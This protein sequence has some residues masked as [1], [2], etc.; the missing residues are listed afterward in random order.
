MYMRECMTAGRLDDKA[1]VIELPE[2]LANDLTHR[3]QCLEVIL[4]LVVILLQRLRLLAH[5]ARARAAWR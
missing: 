5:C 1:L 2:N 3:L 4:R